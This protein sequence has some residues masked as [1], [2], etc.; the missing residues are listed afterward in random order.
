M[1][2]YMNTKTWRSSDR[3]SLDSTLK[4]L[5]FSGHVVKSCTPTADGQAA[6]IVYESCLPEKIS[7]AKK[8]Y[9]YRTT[10]I[11]L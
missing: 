2:G 8:I 7:T 6:V 9:Y 5:T 3:E 4:S 1:Q 11:M 10:G